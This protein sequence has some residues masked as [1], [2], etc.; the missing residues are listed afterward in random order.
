MFSARTRFIA[1]LAGASFLFAG[2]NSKTTATP[3]NFTAGLNAY[4]LDHP[5][6]LLPDAPRFP[7]ETGDPVQTKQMNALVAAQ[8]LEVTVEHDIHVSR[9]TLTPAGERVAPRFCY[10]H[11][12]VSS[13]DSFTPPAQANGFPE[14]TVSYHYTMDDVR[15]WANSDAIR[16]AF[17]A[18]A[19]ATSGTA[20]DKTTLARTMAGW[21]VPD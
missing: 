20:S 9:Y 19:N 3:A 21:Q 12:V 7:F 14:T 13:I 5:E 10:G 16:A 2:C 11:R 15:I 1:L 6:C 4:F 17:P 8:L 18:M